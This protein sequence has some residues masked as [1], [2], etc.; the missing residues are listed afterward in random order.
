M[1]IQ[2]G[3]L[4]NEI[5]TLHPKLG[6]IISRSGGNLFFI[7]LLHW[8]MFETHLNGQSMFQIVGW[9]VQM[10]EHLWMIAQFIQLRNRG[11]VVTNT[12]L[13]GQILD[14]INLRLTPGRN[15][16]KRYGRIVEGIAEGAQTWFRMKP[17]ML[18]ITT[19]SNSSTKQ[20]DG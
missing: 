12:F 16:T 17:K 3:C 18:Q 6:R 7:G 19:I 11:V 10:F 9:R 13:K 20:F 8:K 1:K 14:L 4:V 15:S 2:F 5:S